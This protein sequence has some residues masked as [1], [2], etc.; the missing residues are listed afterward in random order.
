MFAA[1]EAV[2]EPKAKYLRS[3]DLRTRCESRAAHLYTVATDASGMSNR[4]VARRQN[5]DERIVRDDK[6]GNRAV[7]VWKVLALPIDAQ[8]AFARALVASIAEAQNEAEE[9]DGGERCA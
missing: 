2:A 5:V 1:V 4:A 8:I 3:S 6:D 9:D 7:H